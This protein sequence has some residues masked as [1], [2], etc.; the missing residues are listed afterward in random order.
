MSSVFQTDRAL[1]DGRHAPA[2]FDPS[3]AVVYRDFVTPQ[4]AEIL[5][6][7]VLSVME[8]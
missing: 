7:Q 8:L 5:A 1:V 3:C 4:E 2:S 6:K